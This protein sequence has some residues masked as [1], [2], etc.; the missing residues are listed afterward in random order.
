[1]ADGTGFNA[2]ANTPFTG[3]Y[4]TINGFKTG[5]GTSLEALVAHTIYSINALTVLPSNIDG[6]ANRTEIGFAVEITV[7]QWSKETLTPEIQ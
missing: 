2:T 5:A 6:K 4:I 1:M 7:K 3:K